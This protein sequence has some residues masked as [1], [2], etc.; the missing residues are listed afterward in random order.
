[1]NTDRSKNDWIVLALVGVLAAVALGAVA[2][3]L[4]DKDIPEMLGDLGFAIV[5]GVL[6]YVTAGRSKSD[7]PVQYPSAVR[8]TADIDE[9]LAAAGVPLA[10]AAAE[11]DLPDIPEGYEGTDPGIDGDEGP[12]YG[13]DDD[14]WFEDDE[15]QSRG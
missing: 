14:D 2:S 1:M 4:L 12:D 10:P 5:G 11:V 7:E 13:A 9:A 8:T 15:E 3:V 6:G